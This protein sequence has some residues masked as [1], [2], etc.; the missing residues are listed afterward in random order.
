MDIWQILRITLRRWYIA[1]PLALL[2]IVASYAA[3]ERVAVEYTSAASVLLVNPEPTDEASGPV[4]PG[5]P[6]D[7]EDPTAL[8]D[9]QDVTTEPPVAGNPWL[10]FSGSLNTAAQAIQLSVSSQD[11]RSQLER[12]GLSPTYAVTP[13]RRNP[14]LVVEATADDPETT[15]RTLERVLALVSEDLDAR[16]VSAGAP[17]ENRI[18]VEVLA[19]DTTPARA[20]AAKLRVQILTLAIGLTVALLA[21][22]GFDT[23]TRQRRAGRDD[24]PRSPRSPGDQEPVLVLDGDGAV[25]DEAEADTATFA[26]ERDPQHDRQGFHVWTTRAPRGDEVVGIA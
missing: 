4:D 10:S 22:V 25:W 8:D 12:E 21:A 19:M 18:R 5:L 1:A 3:A 13:D 17:T 15:Q 7:D 23:I 6:A 9:P 26:D 2:A 14:I 20:T 11:T 24:R 16:Q